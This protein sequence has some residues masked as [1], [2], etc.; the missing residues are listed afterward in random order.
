MHSNDML[1]LDSNSYVAMTQSSSK[2]T[3]CNC[4]RIALYTTAVHSLWQAYPCSVRRI[5]ILLS[6]CATIYTV[7]LYLVR[8]GCAS[9][10]PGLH[11]EYGRGR[12]LPHKQGAN[13]EDC[14]SRASIDLTDQTRNDG[15][16]Q[17]TSTT[18]DLCLRN[19]DARLS[20]ETSPVAATHVTEGDRGCG[21]ATAIYKLGRR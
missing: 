19:S 7:A 4:I 5:R 12:V 14:R 17:G 8:A 1:I 10:W 15:A 2:S 6:F 13:Q 11:R 3:I 20:P 21:R 18:T 9:S 16:S